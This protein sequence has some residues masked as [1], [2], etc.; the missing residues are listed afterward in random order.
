MRIINSSK[1]KVT[2]LRSFAGKKECHRRILVSL[3]LKKI[4]SSRILNNNN[5]VLGQ[6]NKI[7]QLVKVESIN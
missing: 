4:G 1:I 5:C 3:G 2:L 6:I 7:I